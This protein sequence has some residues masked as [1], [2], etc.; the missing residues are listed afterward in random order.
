MGFG[1][2]LKKAFENDANLPPEK[3]S[4]T[5]QPV[6]VEFLPSKKSVKAF[7]GQSVKMIAKAAGVDIKYKC[8]KGECRTCE[9]NF[10]GKIVKACQSYLPTTPTTKVYQI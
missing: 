1:D 4:F 9:I 3:S 6:V 2:M 5:A 7:P 10:D 8:E